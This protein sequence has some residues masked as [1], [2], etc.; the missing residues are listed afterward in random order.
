MRDLNCTAVRLGLEFA[1]LGD[2]D[3][4]EEPSAMRHYVDDGRR[5]GK[6][7]ADV[8]RAHG[9]RKGQEQLSRDR[10]STGRATRWAD[11]F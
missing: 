11:S 5:A 8:L 3:R 1:E 9:G 4:S 6:G 2:G 7:G 10:E